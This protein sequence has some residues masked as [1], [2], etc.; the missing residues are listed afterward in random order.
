MRRNFLLRRRCQRDLNLVPFPGHRSALP[1]PMK[2][3]PHY[4]SFERGQADF[5]PLPSF[6][7]ILAFEDVCILQAQHDWRAGAGNVVVLQ[8]HGI[9]FQPQTLCMNRRLSAG[10]KPLSAAGVVPVLTEQERRTNMPCAPPRAKPDHRLHQ[11]IVSLDC[12]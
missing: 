12:L 1:V 3:A 11:F 7:K 8:E 4:E 10:A 2:R 9:G 6:A 5:I